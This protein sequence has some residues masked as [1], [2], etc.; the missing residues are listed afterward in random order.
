MGGL[1][2]QETAGPA[3][4]DAGRRAAGQLV[5]PGKTNW[6]AQVRLTQTNWSAQV[7]LT[8]TNWLAQVRPT[9]ASRSA[10]VRPEY[11]TGCK[12]ELGS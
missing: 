5:S 8:Q 10:Q 6:S 2:Q 12:W 1:H 11:R 4:P 9:Q 3:H 7:R